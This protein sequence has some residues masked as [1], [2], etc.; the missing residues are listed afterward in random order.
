[1]NRAG[2]VIVEG[3]VQGLSNTRALGECGVPVIV[4][5]RHNCLARYSKY[6]DGF[7]K[8]PDYNSPEFI[9]FLLDLA[10]KKGLKDWF[11]FPSN[12]HAVYNISVN[13]EKLLKYYKIITPEQHII[14]QIYNKGELLKVGQL[15]GV[16]IPKT[17]YFEK[18]EDFVFENIKYPCLVK[19]KFGLDFYKKT[20]KKAFFADSPNGLRSTLLQIQKEICPS[21]II[22]QELI[23]IKNNK[24]ISCTVFAI[25]GEV[26]TYW[27][28]IKIR[29]HPLRFGT[30]TFTKSIFI[31][32]LLAHSKKLMSNLKYTGTC[33]I[34]F[35]YDKNQD[36]YKLIEINA[37]TWLWVDLAK[38]CGINYAVLSY[39][40]LNKIE[41]TYKNVYND[42][43]Q[44]IH[45]LTDI[46]YSLLGLLR[47][48]YK[49]QEIIISYLKFPQPA[50]F[51]KTDIL[52]SIAE[53]FLLPSFIRKR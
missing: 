42:K 25:N 28:G 40:Y 2:T 1:M 13:H 6:C 31:N 23:P 38:R 11:L 45:Y 37:R 18:L 24:T 44:W 12:D 47:G 30:A 15:C 51:Q 7:F 27:M 5:D 8:C 32:E 50:V 35:I 20:G 19:G 22:I 17:W 53:F 3:H 39:N 14:D 49:I 36:Q 16:P 52:P 26:M 46:P 34:E 48:E 9:S 41:N 29:E 43:L 4:V 10:K 33:E 21:E